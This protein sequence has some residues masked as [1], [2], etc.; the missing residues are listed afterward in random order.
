M[1]TKLSTIIMMFILLVLGITGC[2]SQVNQPAPTQT[3]LPEATTNPDSAIVLDMVERMNAGDLEGSLAYFADDAIAYIIGLPPTGMEVYRGKDQIRALWKDS[4]EN[5]FQWEVKITSAGNNIVSVK[6]KTWHDFTRQLG[7]APLEYSDVYDIKD[8]KIFT[9]GTVITA[10][11]LARFKPAL[12]KA[13]PP[14]PT[15]TPSTDT[16]VSD[17]TIIISDGTCSYKG[18]MTLKTGQINV[19]VNVQDQEKTAYALTF[20][21]LDSGKDFMDLMA[22]TVQPSPPTWSN[23]F[24]IVELAPG[25]SKNYNF[26]AKEEPIYLVCWSKYPELAIGNAGPFEVK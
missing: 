2:S 19:T 17:L 4:I 7:V 24:S 25:T 16:P 10:D 15:A 13:M 23:M 21:T 18:S 11:A 12:A 1:K 5:H 22:S 26:T 3:P 20:F 8:G 14:E 9:Y 6:A